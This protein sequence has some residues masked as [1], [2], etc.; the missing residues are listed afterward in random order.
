MPLTDD[1]IRSLWNAEPEPVAVLV[2][3]QT[4][5]DPTP[6]RVTDHPDGVVSNGDTFQHCPFEFAWAGASQEQ[7]FG[8]A[9]LAIANVDPRIEQGVE[10]ANEPPQ[11]SVGL[12][13]VAAPNVVEKAI[14]GAR[15]GAVELD[16]AKVSALI[17]P[18]DFNEEPACQASYTPARTPSLF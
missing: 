2:T 4:D 9:R 1:M 7:P 6:I 8:E 12:V 5:A 13:R 3:I 17:R 10:A 14:S 16:D 11:V 15:V 18:R